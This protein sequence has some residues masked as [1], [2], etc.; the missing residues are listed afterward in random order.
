MSAPTFW[1]PGAYPKVTTRDPVTGKSSDGSL[2]AEA[3]R[4][5]V[6][7]SGPFGA[8]EGLSPWEVIYFGRIRA[9]GICRVDGGK[10]RIVDRNGIPGSSGEV[11]RV[12]RY[13]LAE[14]TVTLT[15]W[16]WEQWDS[17]C[18]LVQF[19]F[20]KPVPWTPPQ[21]PFQ[22]FGGQSIT[23]Q[24]PALGPA[25]G[26]GTLFGTP[27][28]PNSPVPRT[29]PNLDPSNYA[30]DVTHPSFA[31]LGV[32]SVY[33]IDIRAPRHIGGQIME[34][35]LDFI[36]FQRPV[37]EGSRAIVYAKETAPGRFTPPPND[38]GARV[39]PPGPDQ[40]STGT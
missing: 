30:V 13:G 5:A 16:T 23:G 22:Q 26:T 12:M 33:A 35:Y 31:C 27:L 21:T 18:R 37:G 24:S 2:S 15:I 10:R 28:V 14:F 19:L 36:E 9:P 25:T 7:D 34:V 39:M 6:P 4:T 1:D 32:K 20:P 29:D 8:E 11:A 38:S 17:F 3:I 40:T